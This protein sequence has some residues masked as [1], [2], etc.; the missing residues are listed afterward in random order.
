[1]PRRHV[2]E[3]MRSWNGKVAGSGMSEDRYDEESFPGKKV[4]KRTRLWYND[5]Y[6]DFKKAEVR[7]YKLSEEELRE[8][9]K[10]LGR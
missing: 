10:R 4:E 2:N 5:S 8:L 6:K 3:F 9:E 1:M 7:V